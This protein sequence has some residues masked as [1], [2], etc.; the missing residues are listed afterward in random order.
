MSS[1]PVL[2]IADEHAPY[3]LICDACGFGIG[4]VLVQKGRPIAYFSYKL[5]SAERNYPTG[6]QEFLAVVLSLKHWRYYLEGCVGKLTV[7][8]DHKPNTYLNSKPPTLLS[9]RQVGW[10]P[11]GFLAR[12]DFEWEYRKGAYN[13]A[14]PLSRNPALMNIQMQ[15]LHTPSEELLVK[16]K[17]GYTK[18]PWFADLQNVIHLEKVDGL[19]R[20]GNG[21]I[22]VPDDREEEVRSFCVSCCHDPPYIGHLGRDRTLEHMRRYFFWPKMKEDVR[23]YIESCD[24]CQR[25]KAANQKPAGS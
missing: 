8:T 11:V 10:Q 14:D 9:R 6:E 25:N 18:D 2:A 1:A 3:E 16:I 21:Q 15:V 20:N 12:F 24:N 5:N 17:Q 7:V 22:L 4:A 23:N 19:Y 13:I